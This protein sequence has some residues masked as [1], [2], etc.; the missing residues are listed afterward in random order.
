TR[1][2]TSYYSIDSEAGAWNTGRTE[3]GGN[4]GYKV[5]YKGGYFPVAPTDHFGDLRDEIVTI[6]ERLGMKVE[7][8]HHEVGT[9]GQAEI[10]W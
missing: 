3:D 8:A 10:N 9:A 4:R 6:M 1:Q 2:N 5:K 7:R